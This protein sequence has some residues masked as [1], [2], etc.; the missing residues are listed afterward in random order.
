MR[1][2]FLPII[3]ALTGC[4]TTPTKIGES[5]NGAIN[6]QES[7]VDRPAQKIIYKTRDDGQEKSNS[8]SAD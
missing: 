4:G 8:Q 2:V 5:V 6:S 3:L 1:I 7:T